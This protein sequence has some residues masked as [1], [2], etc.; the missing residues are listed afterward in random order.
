TQYEL[1][2]RQRLG[3]R[4]ALT[5]SGFYRTQE[6]KI[7]NRRLDGGFPVY[8]T[9]RNTDFTTTKGAELG[10]ELRRTN[11]LAINANYTL[12]FAQG[13]GSDANATATI[14]WRGQY[15]PQFIS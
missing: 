12:A 5:L 9:Y 6:N 8:G 3:E 13:T 14:V 11:N 7:S 2:F 10:F 15:F 4:A 1:G